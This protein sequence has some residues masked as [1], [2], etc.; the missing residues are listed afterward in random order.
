MAVTYKLIETITVGSGG[1]ANI[2]FTSIPQTYTDLL[3]LCS[4]RSGNASVGD[5]ILIRFNGLTTNLSSR[6]VYGTGSGT[7]SNNYASIAAVG[8]TSAASATASTFGNCSLYIPNYASTTVNKSVSGDGVA[9]NN[10]TT[11][12]SLFGSGL[13]SSTAAITQINI[14]PNAGSAWL[15]YSSASLYGIKNS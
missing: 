3:I 4:T 11:A 5:D 1:A 2:E 15:Q 10:A 9:E 8:Y 6:S 14:L 7:G 12:V 13:W